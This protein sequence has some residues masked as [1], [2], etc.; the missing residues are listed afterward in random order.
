M[1]KSLETLINKKKVISFD[2]FDTLIT[3]NLD[4]PTDL[5]DIVENEIRKNDIE[6]SNFREKR[7]ASEKTLTKN[8]I[9]GKEITLR[10]IYRFMGQQYHITSKILHL[11]QSMEIELEENICEINST[12]WEIYN[13]SLKKDK[14]VIIT[15]DM[16]LPKTTVRKILQINR[17]FCHRLYLSCDI[18]ASKKD[19]T[20]FNYILRDLGIEPSEML[21]IGDNRKSD[22]YNPRKKG[23]DSILIKNQ[24]NNTIIDKRDLSFPYRF[25]IHFISNHI[26]TCGDYFYKL[27]YQTL[28]PLLYGYSV[29][30]EKKLRNKGYDKVFFLSRDGLIMQK[31]FSMLVPDRKSEY[32]YASRQALITPTLWMYE[33]LSEI[34][35]ISYFS[36]QMS[37]RVFLTKMGL[38]PEKY[39]DAVIKSGYTLE[40][41]IDIHKEA[42]KELFQA[43]WF[44]IY[45]DIR[46]NSIKEF[47]NMIRYFEDINFQG[48]VAIID[49]GWYGHM[50]LAVERAV[51]AS[52]I[53]AE[54]DGYYIGIYPESAIAETLNMSG[55]VFEKN[56]NEIIR[57]QKR[58]FNSIFELT[59]TAEHGSVKKYGNSTPEF[60]DYEYR[61]TGTDTKIRFIQDGALKFIEDYKNYGMNKYI[62]LD[63]VTS[64]KNYLQLGNRPA[65][66]DIEQFS[67]I[68]FWDD[69][70]ISLIPKH[71]MG[72]YIFHPNCFISE[73]KH[74]FW[75]TGFLKHLIHMDIDYYRLANFLR[76]IRSCK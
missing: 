35:E 4:R 2:L 15:T 76:N 10:D 11:V 7:V 60:C 18:N 32:M 54:I 67:E 33:N 6:L 64:I 42:H 53:A 51:K 48:K 49:I 66:H 62:E 20:L 24:L 58:Y 70:I 29:W 9:S 65:M 19:G 61:E 75:V 31:A 23:I 44:S 55:Y 3:R 45:D 59:F 68:K 73:L 28:G 39:R 22:Y 30:L 25:L 47:N 27:G 52:E 37:I 13:Y 69:E 72:Y 12:I 14:M 26:N 40:Q 21:H 8:K 43:L 74:S 46:N 34:I 71:S 63:E 5:F 36:H 17:L 16:Y 38:E 41:Y 57:D 1:T 50:Q 56:K